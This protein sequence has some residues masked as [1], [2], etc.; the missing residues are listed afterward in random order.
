MCVNMHMIKVET[1]EATCT[2]HVHVH[3]HSATC[4]CMSHQWYNKG[5]FKAETTSNG[6]Y[7]TETREHGSKEDDLPDTRVH[8]EIGEVMA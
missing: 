4:T 8:G 1:L 3:S 5:F 7:W 2:S 6:E